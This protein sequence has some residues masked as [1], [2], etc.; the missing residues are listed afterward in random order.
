MASVHFSAQLRSYTGGLDCIE[1]AG[2]T[3]RD[4]VANI[5]Q[6]FPALEPILRD[7]VAV[8]IDGEI[9]SDPFLEA[10]GPHSEVHFLQRISGG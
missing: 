1:V 10:V 5:A 6:R 3:Y 8:A 2:A 7:E 9:I 4:L